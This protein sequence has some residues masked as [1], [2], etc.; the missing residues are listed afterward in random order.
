[1]K[2]DPE[3]ERSQKKRLEAIRARR[4]VGEVATLLE[5][6]SNIA[7]GDE[8]LIPHFVK[9]VKADITL[10]EICDRLRIVWGEFEPSVTV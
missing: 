6:L 3:I 1:M 10:G 4:D 8:N 5:Q 9:C 7:Q 2:L